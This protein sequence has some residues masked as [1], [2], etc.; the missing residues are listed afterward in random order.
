MV[1]ARRFYATEEPIHGPNLA[2]SPD[3]KQIAIL[4]GKR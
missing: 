1:F 3:G 2:W 4:D